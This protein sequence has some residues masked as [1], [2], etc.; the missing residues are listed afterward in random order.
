[1]V[2]I[3]YLEK[4]LHQVMKKGIENNQTVGINL[5]IKKDGQELL[6]CQEGMADKEKGKL[7]SRDT[8]F[9]L[10]SM[11]K[12]VTAV[13]A[14]IL[15]ERGMLDLYEPV[16]SFLPAFGDKKGKRACSGAPQREM[17][18]L[19]LLRMT[20]GL[21]YPD[22]ET[23]PGKASGLVFQEA[24]DRIYTNCPMSTRELS[25]KLAAGPLAFEPGSSWRYGTSADVLGAVIEA[26]SGK[27][28][29]EFLQEEIFSPLKM[30]D[31]AFWVPEEKKHRLATVYEIQQ[32]EKGNDYMISYTGDHLAIRND[33]AIPPAYESGGAGLASALDDYMKFAQMLLRKGEIDG[34]RILRPETVGYLEN[35]ELNPNQQEEFDKWIGLDGFS[36][37]NLMRVCKTPDRSGMLA[38]KG[39]YGWDG[40]LGTYFA[41]FPQENMT[42]LMGMQTKDT[43]T[44]SLTRKIRNVIL[45]SI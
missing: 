14:M 8:I 4:M 31:T 33:M 22:P 3:K 1:M 6:Y 10:Y 43:G 20:S 32:S 40:W 17:L 41:N 44:S 2:N 19:D 30:E 36:Y 12:P 24:L 45:A 9:R 35:G 23:E 39:E 16:S 34:I 21:V 38:R 13:A 29:S 28:F 42:I 7:M 25:E 27:R 15:M 26:V 5:L 18:V 11:T 37:G